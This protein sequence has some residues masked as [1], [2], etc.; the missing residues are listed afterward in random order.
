MCRRTL[1]AGATHCD[2]CG[3]RIA[4]L[5]RRSRNRD[6]E[7]AME[8]I[9]DGS[10]TAGAG[11]ATTVAASLSARA[12]VLL[13]VV[14]GLLLSGLAALIAFAVTRGAAFAVAWSNAA[15]FTGGITMTVAVVLGGIRVSRLLGDVELMKQRARGEGVRAAH[16]HV[17]LGIATAAAL[18]LALAIG[19]AVTAR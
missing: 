12:A 4:A 14:G 19:L 13:G 6:V 17:R 10:S 18:P 3:L 9:A 11:A 15:F 2:R 1:P 8:A 16:D 5:P 7:V